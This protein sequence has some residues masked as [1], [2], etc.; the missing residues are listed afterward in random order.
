MS[1][2]LSEIEE[3]QIHDFTLHLG[4]YL[5]VE[6]EFFNNH[7]EIKEKGVPHILLDG[8]VKVGVQM[9]RPVR[10]LNFL[11]PEIQVRQFLVNEILE[12]IALLQ[13]AI[14]AAHH[15]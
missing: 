6:G 15:K 4:G 9:M 14:D 10:S 1:E 8:A 12:P 13:H 5:L 3:D 2:L 11:Y 7:V